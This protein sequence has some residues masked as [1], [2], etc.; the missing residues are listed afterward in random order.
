MLD[1]S[2][3]SASSCFTK[4]LVRIWIASIVWL[5]D[6]CLILQ[7]GDRLVTT[8][9]VRVVNS[10]AALGHVVGVGVLVAELGIGVGGHHGGLYLIFW[11]FCSKDAF[12]FKTRATLDGRDNVQFFDL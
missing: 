1:L 2:I 7:N 4:S 10:V 3:A 6:T 12:F 11:T 9:G 8:R 5:L